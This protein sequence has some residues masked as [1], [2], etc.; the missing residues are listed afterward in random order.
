MQNIQHFNTLF[1]NSI[2]NKISTVYNIP[3][4]LGFCSNITA[5]GMNQVVA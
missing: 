2:Y 4:H 1:S 3:V 5:F